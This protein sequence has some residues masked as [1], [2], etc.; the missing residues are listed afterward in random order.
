MAIDRITAE[1]ARRE[2][3]EHGALLVCAYPDEA[4]CAKFALRGSISL[5]AFR[6][7]EPRLLPDTR[8]LFYCA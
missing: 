7:A 4:Y 5:K 8:V 2:V 1:D 6:E 3:E